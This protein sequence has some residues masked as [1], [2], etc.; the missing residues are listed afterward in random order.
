MDNDPA[1]K[2][3]EAIK[4]CLRAGWDPQRI[5]QKVATMIR[6]LDN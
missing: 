3:E 6:Y 1:V 5:K 4:E 2:L